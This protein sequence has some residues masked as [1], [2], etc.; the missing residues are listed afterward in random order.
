MPND[1]KPKRATIPAP[2]APQRGD[3]PAIPWTKIIGDGEMPLTERSHRDGQ[4]LV[5]IVGPVDALID[6]PRK[7]HRV[8]D[9]SS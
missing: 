1:S 2:A 9:R 7:G 6:L 4:G 8:P 3:A 5:V